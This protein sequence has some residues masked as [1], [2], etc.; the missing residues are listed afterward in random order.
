[1]RRRSFVAGLSSAVAMPFAASAQQPTPLIGFLSSAAANAPSGPDHAIHLALKQAGLEVGKAVRMEYR[2]A[3]NRYERL[4][5]L[6]VELLRMSPAVI[7]T[8]GGPAPPL[9]VKAANTTVPIVF[10]PIS[11]PVRIGLVS[12]LNRPGGHMTGIAALTIELDPK[13]LELLNELTEAKGPFGVLVN[14]TRPD[15]NLQMEGISAAAKSIGRE[16]VIAPAA[17]V[18][19]IDAALA[20][21]KQKG[22]AGLLVGADPFFTAQRSHIIEQVTR[23]GWP[24]IYQWREFAEAGGLASF[25]P[26][27]FDLYRQVGLIAARI[28]KG[29]KPANLPVMQPTKFEFVLNLRTARALGLTVPLPLL[30]RADEIIE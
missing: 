19:D 30:G 28:I 11:D 7:I 17:N 22:V 6:V 2:F 3:E 21:L 29:E 24:A 8:S 12:S 4:P 20:M 10:A 16:L 1:M 27:L 15:L 23:Y 13:R 26:N 5:E 25:G 18:P 14:S 9:A